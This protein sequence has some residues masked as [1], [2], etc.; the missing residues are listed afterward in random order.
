MELLE[1]IRYV[2]SLYSSRNCPFPPPVKTTA[3]MLSE[4]GEPG[5]LV[6]RGEESSRSRT[7]ERKAASGSTR[8]QDSPLAP[9]SPGPQ[10]IPYKQMPGLW[11]SKSY[12]HLKLSRGSS[13][14]SPTWFCLSQHS[15][16]R[17]GN[18]STDKKSFLH[19]E[20]KSKK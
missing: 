10:L 7:A 11:G 18:G 1:E 3:M 6:M 20:N 19:S 9:G 15:T 16:Y 17:S 2:P 8:K 12:L 5:F 4:G 14:P 13:Q